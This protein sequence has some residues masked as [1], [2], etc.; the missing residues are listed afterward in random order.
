MVLSLLT[1]ILQTEKNKTK[2]LDAN[3]ANEIYNS[4]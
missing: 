3:K 4:N 1:N 2:N